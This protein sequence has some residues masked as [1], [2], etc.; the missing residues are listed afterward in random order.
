MSHYG[1]YFSVLSAVAL[2]ANSTNADSRINE[3]QYR[4]STLRP[5]LKKPID[6]HV[7]D[8]IDHNSAASR[9]WNHHF[10]AQLLRGIG[11]PLFAD[12]LQRCT[13]RSQAPCHRAL[14]DHMTKTNLNPAEPSDHFTGER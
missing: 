9:H 7:P 11:D 5:P 10:V 4:Y 2:Q 14:A 3:D 12:L 8:T 13:F 6:V 1:L